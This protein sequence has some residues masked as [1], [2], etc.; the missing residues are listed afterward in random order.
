MAYFPFFI[1]IAGADGLVVGGGTVALRKVEKLLPYS[2]RLTLIAPDIRPELEEIPGLTIL[3]RAAQPQD[4]EGRAFVI[5]A[6][7]DRTVNA[8]FSRLCRERNIPV[9]VVDNKQESSF[10]FPCLIKRGSLSVGISTGGDSP[11]AAI[12][13]KE[14]FAALI[15]GQ[16]EEILDYLAWERLA[17][18]ETVPQLKQR[19][20]ILKALF[21]A[22]M[23][24]CRPLTPEE[25]TEIVRKLEEK[26]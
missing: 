19:E 2:P 17:V 4:L 10:L 6:A 24:R 12:Y 23:E 25:R 16:M 5:A 13:W 18:K 8:Q 7:G 20:A 15:P 26:P 9:N 22:C 14:R 11:S 3:R 1:D 21:A